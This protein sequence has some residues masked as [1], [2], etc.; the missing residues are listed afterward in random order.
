MKS[1]ITLEAL[2][3]IDA[4]ERRGSFAKAAEELGKATSAL[5]YIVQKLEQQLD[6]TLFQRQGRRSVL[7]PAGRVLLD[8][9]RNILSATRILTEKTREVATGWEPR[10]RIAAESV[11]DYDILFAQLSHFL[12]RHPSIELDICECVLGGGWDALE[13]DRVDLV[14]GAPGPTPTQKGFR[15]VLLGENDMTPVIAASHPLAQHAGNRKQLE[16]VMPELRRIITHDTTTTNIARTAGLASGQRRL[17]VQ[18]TEQKLAAIVAGL[19][20]G[21]LP[22]KR[23]SEHLKDKTLVKLNL[24][25]TNRGSSYLAWKLAHKGRGLRALTQQLMDVEWH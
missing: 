10:L 17:Y 14:I 4:I 6:V 3:A 25:P 18:T 13:D 20:V 12:Q 1:L 16:A 15:S 23:I 24:G 11:I 22:L 19:G 9:G 2:E 5:S 21:H 8:D 7:T